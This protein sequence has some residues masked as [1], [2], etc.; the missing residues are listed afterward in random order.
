MFGVHALRIGLALIAQAVPPPLPQRTADCSR[1]VYASDQLLC[2]EPELR[3]MDRRLA[4]LMSLQSV[5]QGAWIE[6]PES[7]F[8]RSRL[9]AM[10]RDHRVCLIDAYRERL[11]L[12][13]LSGP[14]PTK[15]CRRYRLRIDGEGKFALYSAD[16][17]LV[18]VG[19]SKD[20]TWRPFV[21]VTKERGR[22]VFR[23]ISGRVIARCA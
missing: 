2:A 3:V 23:G 16:G 15:Q 11:A 21:G 22:L 19:V 6:D 8:K 10:A 1:P 14:A 12:M 20:S 9:C 5:P 17:S 18:A 13:T 7:W 4:T